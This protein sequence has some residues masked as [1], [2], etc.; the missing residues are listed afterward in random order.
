M[1][2][3]NNELLQ[4]VYDL[5]YDFSGL[6][7][8]CYKNEPYDGFVNLI[9]FSNEQLT[10]DLSQIFKEQRE[11]SNKLAGLVV[12][13]DEL[14]PDGDLWCNNGPTPFLRGTGFEYH[15]PVNEKGVSCSDYHTL[16]TSSF[17][18]EDFN[19]WIDELDLSVDLKGL[20]KRESY[21]IY[22]NR[23][24][25]NKIGLDYACLSVFEYVINL[26]EIQLQ[27]KEPSTIQ[28][29]KCRYCGRLYER[30]RYYEKHEKA[31]YQN[32][33][34]KHRCLLN[35]KHLQKDVTDKQTSFKCLKTGKQM[36]SYK[37]EHNVHLNTRL[38]ELGERMPLKCEHYILEY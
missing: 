33:V 14:L 15:G 5:K 4:F 2:K 13:L 19:E 26:L 23:S 1:K 6:Y 16:L 20:I 3:L 12:D 32:P 25:D 24:V 36:Y 17:I 18:I 35:C 34:N 29:Y 37:A 9:I 28:A 22:E 21:T 8:R 7:E 31:C 10:S 11:Y 27:E 30:K 38:G